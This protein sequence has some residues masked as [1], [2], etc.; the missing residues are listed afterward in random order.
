[1]DS[2]SDKIQTMFNA[3]LREMI[4]I[5]DTSVRNSMKE[6]FYHGVLLGILNFRTDWIIRSNRE[7]GEGYGDIMIMHE[8]SGTG[9]II[10]VK[11]AENDN[12]EAECTKAFEQI[13]KL[14]YTDAIMEY[15]PVKIYKYAI[16]CYKKHC[17]VEVKEDV[18]SS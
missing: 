1:M 3:Y 12:L 9:M 18:F 17:R 13:E 16:A 2:D 4:S 10:E 15:D 14:H 7:S 8:E 11:Y 5:R 6:N